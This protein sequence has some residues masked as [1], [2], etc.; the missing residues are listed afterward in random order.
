MQGAISQ[1]GRGENEPPGRP[2][3]SQKTQ[4]QFGLL[5]VQT[6]V[7]IALLG[8]GTLNNKLRAKQEFPPNVERYI[9]MAYSRLGLQTYINL[10]KVFLFFFS[11]L[12]E[13]IL[14]IFIKCCSFL[15]FSLHFSSL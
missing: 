14:S 2:V 11:P 12:S 4:Q 10:H 15:P 7:R 5:M 13:K 3:G 1:Q 9:E 6:C 8:R